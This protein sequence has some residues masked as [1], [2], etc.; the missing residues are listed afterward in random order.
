[1]VVMIES[2]AEIDHSRALRDDLGPA[3]KAG[4][5]MSNVAVVALDGN[6]EVLAGEQLFR[7]ISGVFPPQSAVTK[8]IPFFPPLW[9]SRRRV[10]SSGRP[11][12]QATVRPPTG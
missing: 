9:R 12:P 10:P 5:E 2:Q 7:G 11:R 1:M 8:V 3:A 6:R 4:Q